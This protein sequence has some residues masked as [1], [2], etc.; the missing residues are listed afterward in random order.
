M[1]Q[2]FPEISLKGRN[3]CQPQ[4]ITVSYLPC[5]LPLGIKN[6]LHLCMPLFPPWMRPSLKPTITQSAQFNFY[7]PSFLNQYIQNTGSVF[8]PAPTTIRALYL[9]YC[10][11]KYLA[12]R[13]PKVTAQNSLFTPVQLKALRLLLTWSAALPREGLTEAVI[14]HVIYPA[15]IN[16]LG[17][18]HPEEAQFKHTAC[19]W[20]LT[21]CIRSPAPQCIRGE[22]DTFIFLDC[23]YMLLT[24]SCCREKGLK[25]IETH[26]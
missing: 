5:V 25:T 19:T 2:C 3:R 20:N 14:V 10:V 6:A 8:L 21:F 18:W 16:S 9:H 15:I 17:E 23:S 1:Y 24:K 11:L 13:I 26:R 7:F 22:C 12:E 4:S